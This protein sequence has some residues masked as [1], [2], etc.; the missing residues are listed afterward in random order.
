MKSVRFYLDHRTPADKRAGRH[1][2]NVTAV[3]PDNYFWSG[4]NGNSLCFEAIAAVYYH[5][6]SPCAGTAVSL[7]WLNCCAKRISEAKAREIH[8]NLFAYLAQAQAVNV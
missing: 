6:D 4:P 2:G 8:P 7:S 1:E 3:F 5:E